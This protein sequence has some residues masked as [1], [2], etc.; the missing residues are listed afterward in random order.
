[1]AVEPDEVGLASGRAVLNHAR[2]RRSRERRRRPPCARSDTVLA[3]R[4][5]QP[6]VEDERARVEASLEALVTDDQRPIAVRSPAGLAREQSVDV[7][8]ERLVAAGAPRSLPLPLL[9]RAEREVEDVGGGP[10]AG[11]GPP[12]RAHPGRAQAAAN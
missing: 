10:V 3:Q 1:M 11:R 2:V 8:A 12:L 7:L 5:A 6:E 4:V 9:D